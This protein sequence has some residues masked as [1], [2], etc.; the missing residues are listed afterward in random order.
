M[1][2]LWILILFFM[3]MLE[4]AI[5]CLGLHFLLPPCTGDARKDCVGIERD[6]PL[7]TYDVVLWKSLEECYYFLATHAEMILVVLSVLKKSLGC[8]ISVDLR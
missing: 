1:A 3:E 8:C 7:L 2:R 6:V 4:S 5:F